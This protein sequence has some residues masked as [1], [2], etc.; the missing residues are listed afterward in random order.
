M[1]H[2]YVVFIWSIL[3]TSSSVW[4]KSLTKENENDLER[5]QKTAFRLILGSRYTSYENAQSLLCLSTLKDRRELLFTKFTLKSL[6]LQQMNTILRNKYKEH[7]METRSK[8]DKFKVDMVN[9]ERLR[10]SAGIQMQITANKYTWKNLVS[11]VKSDFLFVWPSSAT[12]A[13][14]TNY[15]TR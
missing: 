5:I 9:T 7:H 15:I 2:I 4:H 12:Y 14:H 10:M 11:F 3:E 8:I 13:C 6:K 1:K